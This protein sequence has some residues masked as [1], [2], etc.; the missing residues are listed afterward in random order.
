MAEGVGYQGGAEIPFV[1]SAGEIVQMADPA[2]TLLHA[3]TWN[4]PIESVC[5]NAE[6]ALLPTFRSWTRAPR[7]ARNSAACIRLAPVATRHDARLSEGTPRPYAWRYSE[8]MNR[9]DVL[10]SGVDFFL[11]GFAF[12]RPRHVEWGQVD[13]FAPEKYTQAGL[14]RDKGAGAKF[15]SAQAWR[16]SLRRPG[17]RSVAL[18]TLL[19]S[20]YSEERAAGWAASMNAALGLPRRSEQSEI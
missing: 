4:T 13:V 11:P 14:S 19:P 8:G 17:Q 9:F 15:G 16:M 7:G 2:P 18:P 20:K 6:H 5:G 10:E 1:T 3:V 12:F